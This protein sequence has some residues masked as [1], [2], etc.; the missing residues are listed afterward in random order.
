MKLSTLRHFFMGILATALVLPLAAFAEAEKPANKKLI[1]IAGKP[2]HGP[3]DHEFN[4][5]CMLFQKC[6]KDIPGLDVEVHNNHWVK[7]D[8]V[9]ETADAVVIYSDGGKG[10][11]ALQSNHSELLQKVANRGG[12]IMMMHYA[13]ECNAGEAATGDLFRSWIGGAYESNF[14][15]NPMWEADYKKFPEHPISRGVSPF[16]IRDEWYFSIRFPEGMVLTFTQK[17]LTH[18]SKPKKARKKP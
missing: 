18:T 14:S 8:A 12:G 6:L 13:V 5:G 3:G 1:L 10:H 9:L 15:C 7:D 16:K 17:V 2:S 11:P 4:A